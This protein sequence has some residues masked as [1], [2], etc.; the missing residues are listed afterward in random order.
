MN[1]RVVF[2]TLGSSDTGYSGKDERSADFK[3][4][5]KETAMPAKAADPALA[6][7]QPIK[8][9]EDRFQCSPSDSQIA[10]MLGKRATYLNM[11]DDDEARK[12]IRPAKRPAI[13]HSTI[14]PKP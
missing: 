10:R 7:K 2:D 3:E 6:Y 1:G 4:P 11:K 13:K 12:R 5:A 8:M 14:N 9:A